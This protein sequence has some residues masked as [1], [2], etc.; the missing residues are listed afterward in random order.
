MSADPVPYNPLI[1]KAWT[2]LSVIVAIITLVMFVCGQPLLQAGH[3]VWDLLR[4][5]ASPLI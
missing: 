1:I 2:V 3:I 4:W 5:L